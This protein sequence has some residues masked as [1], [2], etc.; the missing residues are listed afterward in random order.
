MESGL[1]VRGIGSEVD[2]R[3]N[4]QSLHGAT[5]QESVQTPCFMATPNRTGTEWNI[6]GSLAGGMTVG[7]TPDQLQNTFTNMFLANGQPVKLGKLSRNPKGSGSN[8]NST[9]SKKI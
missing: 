6:G 8:I 7:L 3:S 2:S 4:K 9:S 5:K 1:I